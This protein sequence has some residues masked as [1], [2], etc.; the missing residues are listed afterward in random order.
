V[1][2]RWLSLAAGLALGVG[3]S[4]TTS[5]RVGPAVSTASA[6]R[7]GGTS[8]FAK[9]AALQAAASNLTDQERRVPH[10]FGPFP[11]WANSPLTLPDAQVVITGDGSGATA[12]ASVGANGSITAI[13]VTN[14]GNGY[15]DARVQILGSG[16]GATA[17]ARINE[18]GYVTSIT[19]GQPGAGYTTPQVTISGGRGTGATAVAYGG[20]DAVTVTDGGSGYT[21]PTVDFDLPDG[22]DGVAAVGHAT[23]DSSGTITGVVVDSPGS[24]YST[25]PNVVIRNGTMYKSAG[26]PTAAAI[27]K[28]TLSLDSIVLTAYGTGYVKPPLVTIADAAGSGTGATATATVQRGGIVDIVVRRPGSGYVTPGGIRKFVDTLPGLGPAAANNL[29]QYIPVA[30]PDTT[31]FPGADYYEIAVVEYAEQMHSDLPPTRL[32]GYVQVQTPVVTGIGYPLPGGKYGVDR[33]HYLG[34]T[35]VARKDRPV[36]ITFH[37][38]LP[39]GAAGDLFLPVDSTV[40]GSGEGMMSAMFDQTPTVGGTVWDSVRNPAC[41]GLSYDE[42]TTTWTVSPKGADCFKDNRATL[43]L[44]GGNT[45]WISDG[46]PHQWITP[47][48]ETTSYRKGASFQNVPDMVGPGKLIPNPTLDD[49]LGT[50]YYTNQQSSRMMWYHDHS[51]GLTRLNVYAG[52]ASAY[53]LSDSV[54]DALIDAGTLPGAGM[55]V[56]RYGIPLIIQDKTFVPDATKLAAT[57]PTWDPASYGGEGSLWFPHVYMPNQNPADISGA[58][59]MGRWDYGPWFWPPVTAAAGLVNGPLPGL[60]PGDP[61]IPG[62]PNPSMVPEAF[63]DTPLVNGCPYPKVTL[64]PRAYRFRIL[65][66]ANDRMFNLQLY[67]VDPAHPTEVKMVPSV[68]HPGDPAWPATWPTDGRDGGVPDPA[69]VGPNFIQIG[70]D[71]GFLPTPVEIPNQPVGYNYNRRDIVVLNVQE[72]SLFLGPAERADVIV[73]FSQVPAG[74]K[75]ILYNDGP[76]PVPAFDTR[77]DYYTGDP[78]QTDTGGAPSTLEG[79]G[80]NTRTLMLI[81]IAGTPA[82]PFDKA[83]LTTA[84]TSTAATTG[85]YQASQ[86]LPIVPQTAY[87]SAFNQTFKDTWSTIQ[88]NYLNYTDPQTGNPVQVQMGSKAIQE[89]FELNYGRMNATLGVELPFTNFNIQTT[90]PLGYIDPAT[91]YLQDGQFQVWKITHNGVDTHPVHF[92]LFDVQLINRVG[93]DGAVRFPDANE[94]GWK[95]TVRMNP[96]EDCIV[97]LRPKAFAL[98]FSIPHSVRPLDP[99]QPVG[100]NITLVNPVDGN[101]ITV[102]ND[103]TDFGWEY[104]WHCHILGHEENDFMRAMILNV[105]DITFSGTVTSGGLPL[106]GVTLTFSGGGSTTTDANGKYTFTHTSHWIGTI[107]ASLLGY[108]FA[109][110]SYSYSNVTTDQPNQDFVGTAS[111]MVSGTVVTSDVPP[112]P[113]AGV[114][115]NLDN[116]GGSAVTDA[117]GAYQVNVPSGWSGSVTPVPVPGYILAPTAYPFTNVTTPQTANFVAT[118]AVAISG[119]ILSGG[120]PLPGVTLAFSNGGGTATT[121]ANGVYTITLPSGWSGTAAPSLAGYLFNPASLSYTNVTANQ[122]AQNYTATQVAVVSGTVT[123]NGTPL[124]GVTLTFSNGGGTTTTDAAGAYRMTLTSGWTG[125]ATPSLAGFVFAPVSRTYSNLTVDQAAQDYVGTAVV[126]ISGT[127]AN[128]ASPLPGVTLAFSTGQTATTDAGGNY[129]LTLPSPWTGTVTPALAGYAFTPAS[130]SYTAVTVDQ[131]AQNYAAAPIVVISGTVTNGAA[132]LPGVTMTFTGGQTV[133]TDVAGTYTMT[134]PAPWTGTVTPSLAGYVFTPASRSYSAAVANQTAQNFAATPVV[135]VSGQV[136]LGAAG[137]PGVTLAFSTGQTATTDAN[138]TYT[139][140]LPSPWTGTVTP[141]KAGYFLTPAATAYTGI[142]T[143]QPNQNYTAVNAITVYGLITVNSVPA[144]PLAGVTVT[145]SNGGGVATTDVN[146]LYTHYV[147]SGWS[148][149]VTPALAG[150]AFTPATRTF[151]NLTAN[152]P[153]QNFSARPVVVVSGQ[154]TSAGA[155]LAGVRVSFSNAGSVTTDATGNYQMTLNAGWTGTVTPTMRGWIFA[156]ASLSLTNVTANLPSQNFST[157]QSISGRVRNLVNGQWVGTPGITM[158]LS[159][160]TTTVTDANGR[161]TLLAPSGWSG[162]LTPSGGTWVYTPAS[163]SYSNLLTNPTGQNFTAQ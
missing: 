28:A 72:K 158:T 113:L 77:Y 152:P 88:A 115:I 129:R 150:Y 38:L 131:A 116:G 144:T 40:M 114:T 134:L 7:I 27:A 104:V 63:M 47:A 71:S 106:P 45:P 155:P 103:P 139:M 22:P 99:T 12:T 156:P 161:Y 43:H 20:V 24:G 133:T 4:R 61:E 62:T 55:G 6:A 159:N 123:T 89:L 57:D 162:T 32:R 138:G 41:T 64:E 126:T 19:L 14:P 2:N 53:F 128:G 80:P 91:E 70:T 52:E 46:T 98:P 109:P 163:L 8:R 21:F 23:M 76:A 151:T 107:T 97:A 67:Y 84:F 145:F 87:N 160:G 117:T 92:H 95:E 26:Q 136:L 13:T 118:S 122:T 142:T 33:P 3:C 83:A 149:T 121:N 143:D 94:V 59:G 125:T 37:N 137:L 60:N 74:S 11:N 25:A 112:V 35:I 157:V 58:N 86:E 73:D 54:E 30:V 69:T 140:T 127:V 48:G 10:Y 90:I 29:G 82:A 56:Y 34:P 68:P 93:W 108:T 148:G 16:T 17:Q 85:A 132:G 154:V 111:P 9:K 110:A 66:A 1:K 50:Y 135:V 146:G 39:T 31:T 15:G 75:L 96:L 42:T 102:K 78:D 36:R 101:P 5:D 153:G 124:A 120:Q 100:A 51:F 119:T 79:Y 81:E 18:N 105:P 65:N 147:P 130:R 44:H 141:S 49:G